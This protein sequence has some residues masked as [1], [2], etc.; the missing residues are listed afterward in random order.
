MN[1]DQFYFNPQV[2]RYVVSGILERFNRF[3]WPHLVLISDLKNSSYFEREVRE[4]A[5][6]EEEKEEKE[7]E[8]EVPH[9]FMV[10]D[11]ESVLAASLTLHSG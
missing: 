2:T 6:R 3:Y 4:K 11:K 5:T 1:V 10:V 8:E 9:R 7:G